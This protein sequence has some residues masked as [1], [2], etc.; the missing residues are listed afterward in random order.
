[1]QQTIVVNNEYKI[2]FSF[3]D[4]EICGPN[5][6][7]VHLNTIPLM[8][9][10]ADNDGLPCFFDNEI[11]L[12][13]NEIFNNKLNILTKEQIV[14]CLGRL[15]FFPSDLIQKY[16]IDLTKQIWKD[17][18]LTELFPKPMI[19]NITWKPNLI[20]DKEH[21]YYYSDDEELIDKCS[22]RSI[23]SK[24]S[25]EQKSLFGK[26]IKNMNNHFVKKIE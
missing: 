25:N 1:M 5:M 26:F 22:F 21:K 9:E 17:T 6:L 18:I 7:C 12:I 19:I 3:Y 24:W 16:K 15:F 13:C 20:F 23:K 14:C 11:I 2:F 8:I 10:N 4:H